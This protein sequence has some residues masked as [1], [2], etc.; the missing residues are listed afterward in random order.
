[1]VEIHLYHLGDYMC[2]KSPKWSGGLK[3]IF[4]GDPNNLTCSIYQ[5]TRA[6]S[7]FRLD[8]NETDNLDKI[9]CFLENV[10][11]PKVRSWVMFK[12]EN[13]RSAVEQEV[14]K[15]VTFP[16]KLANWEKENWPKTLPFMYTSSTK[17]NAQSLQLEIRFIFNLKKK[18]LIDY[19]N[20]TL[21]MI[22]AVH[23]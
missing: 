17:I 10:R 8:E 9:W 3:N 18:R 1:M 2:G 15:I 21:V 23:R 7:M 5:M 14:L 12:E 16:K 6:S 20:D 13:S 4:Y 11:D 19:L 22:W